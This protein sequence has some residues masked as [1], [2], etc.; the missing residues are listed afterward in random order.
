[1]ILSTH[2]PFNIP[3][4]F[5]GFGIKIEPGTST[6]ITVTPILYEANE[7]LKSIPIEKR[8]CKFEFENTLKLFKNY[9]KDGCIF[10]CLIES[11][12]EIFHCIPWDYPHMN[13]SQITCLP[14]MREI[15]QDLMKDGENQLK[16]EQQCVRECN[17]I[18]YIPSV[19]SLPLEPPKLTCDGDIPYFDK[20]NLDH[21]YGIRGRGM[22]KVFEKIT[23]NATFGCDKKAF[24]KIA[25]I[26]VQLASNRVTKI[27]TSKRVSFTDHIANLGKIENAE[28]TT[29]F[30]IHFSGGTLGLF[31]G[32]SIMSMFELIFW[33]T[34][35]LF[36]LAKHR[37]K[38]ITN[39]MV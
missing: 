21:I 32:I 38:K 25:I 10:E 17:S 24:S 19:S 26:E 11:A 34:R 4:I 16:C 13:I 35:L 28:Y 37:N 6:M 14:W 20:S 31:T 9:S 15:F 29:L 39:H 33:I 5:E 18:E 3:N 36:G 12:F 22:I 2:S 1:M 27:V 7:N 8:N 23:K 30:Q